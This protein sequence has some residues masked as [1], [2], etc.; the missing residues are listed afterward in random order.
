MLIGKHWA[1]LFLSLTSCD[2]IIRCTCGHCIVVPTPGEC[3]C[4]QEN[5]RM[6]TK[7]GEAGMPGLMCIINH[8]G[9]QTV[10]LGHWVLHTAYYQYRQEHGTAH[11]P[12]PINE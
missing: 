10:C 2:C 7:M 11:L 9:F 6:I 3:I 8:P 4:C 12:I 1:I 5:V